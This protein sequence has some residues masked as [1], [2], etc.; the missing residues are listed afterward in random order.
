MNL[1]Q[2]QLMDHYRNPRNRQ[3]LACPD[4]CSQVY[5]PSCGDSISMQIS[6]DAGMIA[7]IGFQGSGCVISQAAA[8][9]L[10][11]ACVG[12]TLRDCAAFDT[13]SVIA[14]VGIDLGPTRIKCALLALDAL[15]ELVAQCPSS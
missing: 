3:I 6:I 10:T 2:E 15:R 12:K 14:F 13:Q 1:Y 7:Q 11:Q 5:N 4:Y 8:S 9:M